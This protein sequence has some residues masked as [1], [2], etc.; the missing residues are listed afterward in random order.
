VQQLGDA[1]HRPADHAGLAHIALDNL[2]QLAG[3][4]L[5]APPAGKIIQ[6]PHAPAL[7]KQRIDR[8]RADEASPAGD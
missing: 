1:A 8:V 2:Q 7:R 3:G 6:H 4:Q 5:L